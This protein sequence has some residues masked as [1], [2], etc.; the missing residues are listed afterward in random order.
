MKNF[1][2]LVDATNDL[3]KRGY[4]AN[5]SLEGDTIDDKAQDIHMTADDFEI[6]E[7]YRFEGQSNPDDMSI[8]YGISSR[9]YNLKGILVNAYG[10]YAD[11]SSSAIAAKLHHHQVSDN[12][13]GDDRPTQ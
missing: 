13:H 2:T 3:T 4:D 11:D 5:L 9:K 8:V 10:T 1:E 12:L 7:F 6:D